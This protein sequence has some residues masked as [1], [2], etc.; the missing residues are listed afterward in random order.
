MAIRKIEKKD[1]YADYRY[2]IVTPEELREANW[3]IELG[4]YKDLGDY[5]ERFT[6]SEIRRMK[7]EDAEKK[8]QADA[9]KKKRIET[10]KKNKAA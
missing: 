6:R 9:R 1:K 5:I 10:V 7:R 4:D 3:M 2:E 8:K